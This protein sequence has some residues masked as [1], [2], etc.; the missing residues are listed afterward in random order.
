MKCEYKFAEG[1]RANGLDPETTYKELEKISE[2]SG[3]TPNAV[4]EAAK[5]P[6]SPLHGYFDWDDNSA[7]NKFRIGQAQTLIRSIKIEVVGG[8]RKEYKPYVRV[9]QC[10]QPSV[11]LNLSK[12]NE[13]QY[14]QV[15]ND[16]RRK[17]DSAQ[18]SLD[19]LLAFGDSTFKNAKKAKRLMSQLKEAVA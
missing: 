6:T 5:S 19:E 17:I 2:S 1:F 15:L 7:A 12:L 3:L 13:D 10:N 9:V 16:F 14:K 4:L 11:Y 8:E 18:K